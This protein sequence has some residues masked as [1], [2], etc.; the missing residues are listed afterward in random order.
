[1]LSTCVVTLLKFWFLQH[2]KGNMNAPQPSPQVP[3]PLR[4]QDARAHPRPRP[5][6]PVTTDQVYKSH[7][8]VKLV[9]GFYGFEHPECKKAVDH[10]TELYLSFMKQFQVRDDDSDDD[11][12]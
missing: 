1:M 2:L 12:E 4:F 5:R 3:P 6:P 8:R 10:D 7:D 9:C 11:S